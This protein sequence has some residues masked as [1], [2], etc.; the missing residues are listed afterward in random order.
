M[1]KVVS[2]V[3]FNLFLCLGFAYAQDVKISGKVTDADNAV[4]PGVN[5][6]VSGSS[7]G[8]ATDAD[9]KF[10]INAP[11]KGSLVFSFIGYVSQT[12]E[13]NG[14]SIIDM[15][16]TQESKTLNEVVV[17][18]YGTQ[19]KTDVTGALSVIST[20]EF[21]QQPV[22]RL[23]QVLQGRATGVQVTQ[24]NGAPGGDSRIRIRGANSVLGNNDPLYVIDGF[25]G[26]DYNLLNPSDI[27]SLQVLKDAA[28]TSIYG[29]R[30]ANGV[31]IITTKKGT[32]GVKVTYEGQGSVSNV[33]KKFDLLPAGE[34]AE[35]VNARASA[36]GS[37]PPFTA[38]QIADYKKN[39]GTDWQDLV[40]RTG[41]GQ[42]HQV[43]V[44]GGNDKTT[45]LVSGNY[46]NQKGIVENS[47]FKRYIFRTNLTTQV[48]SK[49]ALR[50][51]LNGANSFNHNTDG[52]GALIEALQWAPT[53]PAYGADGLPTYSDPTG[54]V[55]RSPL[56][57]LYDK[58]NDYFKTN[59]NA[60]GGLNYQLPIKGLTLDLQYAIN[61]L[62]QQNKNFNGSRIS[63]N[64]PNAS[65]YSSDQVTLQNTNALNYNITIKNHSINAVAV[66][67][68]QQYTNKNFTANASGLRFPQLGYD[69]I[70]GNSASSVSSGFQ[71]WT[72]LSFLGRV[73]YAFKDKYLVS[74][75]VRRDGSSKFSPANRYSVF[76]SVALGWRLS[77][78]EFIK[79]LNVFSNLK[80]RG[81]WGMTGSQAIN[82]YAT[83]SSYNT[84]FVSYNNNSITA[85]VIQGNA[86]N[87]DLKWETT[88]QTDVGVEMEF[89]NGRI[90][91]E[92]DYFHK[93]TTD[94]LLNVSIPSYAGGGTQTRNVGEIENKGFEFSIGGSPVQ[95]KFGWETNL[96]FSTLRNK[97]QDLGGLPRL[98]TGTGTGGGM[99]ITNEFMLMPG[100]PLGSY[101]GLKYLGTFK[102]NEADIAAKQGRVPGDPHYQDLNGDNSITTDD[103]QIIGHAFPKMTGGWNNTFTYGGFTLNVF[104]NAVFGVDKLN[105]T[106]AGA[107]SGSGEARQFLLTE[108]RDYYR[109]GNETSD[110][111]A[112]TSTY[113]PFTQSSR[114][115]ENGSFVRLKNVSLSYTIPSAKLKNVGSI[116]V[117]GSATNLFTITKYSGPDP[118]SS[119]VGSGT[120]TAIG[121]DRGS[122]PNAKVYT[123][124][125]NL[126]F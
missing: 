95:G 122:Y 59:V 94:L 119:N 110:I 85:G 6:L 103:F 78:E 76:P 87:K 10:T 17:V 92:A 125:L 98:G 115:I 44:T 60:I 37:T 34:F 51:N 20:K 41:H 11:A 15:Q 26:A 63:N 96:N 58:S 43:T 49:L 107:M 16:L 105:Y 117:F 50:F 53:T 24:S 1:K 4:L 70:G 40:Y 14:R 112:F 19:K 114:F 25:I 42:Q 39:G 71:K 61:Y 36:T 104:M 66:L 45:F 97:V 22:T 77:E 74:A 90:R 109:P 55:S 106:R 7:Q 5:I 108:I 31:V 75:A 101:W 64:V 54:S 118:E 126:S 69:N 121:I 67:E 116:R 124:G 93:N 27:A 83:L 52:G 80:L 62:D 13:I 123:L 47:S 29:S 35:I 46:V 79:N 73:N 81:S 88:K 28:S 86:G 99:S 38:A 68:T 9:G 102:P 82:P 113:Q 111:P 48:N 33:I 21:A 100:A 2:L 30:G 32:K 72:L 18:G 91:M 56:D 23:D 84:T 65:R 12:V 8:T 120:D 89:L 3:F 57:N